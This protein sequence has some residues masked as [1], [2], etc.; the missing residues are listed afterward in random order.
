MS[1]RLIAIDV[2]TYS[3]KMIRLAPTRRTILFFKRPH[4]ALSSSFTFSEQQHQSTDISTPSQG[5]NILL[6]RQ[7]YCFPK[8]SSFPFGLSKFFP[9]FAESCSETSVARGRMKRESGEIPE[10]SRC[11]EPHLHRLSLLTSPPLPNQGG[12]AK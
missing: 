7:V 4:I 9:T 8:K 11:C 3:R 1:I 12:K 6:C 2:W 10:Q 5:G